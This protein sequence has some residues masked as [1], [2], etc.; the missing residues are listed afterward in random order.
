MEEIAFDVGVTRVIDS[1]LSDRLALLVGAGL[2]MAPP[3]SLPSAAAIAASAKEK[4]D[5]MFGATRP[6]LATA[7]EEQ[8]E[9][10][11]QRGELAGFYF[12]T[13]IDQNAFAGPP[14]IGHN[15][16]ADLLL[17]RAI[18]TAVT[19]NVDTLIET[20]GQFLFGQIGVGIDRNG[21]AALRPD[22]SPLLKI[23]GC[24]V[25]DCPN[26]VWAPGQ[27][28]AAPVAGRIADSAEWLN[29]RL[30]D[31]DLLIVG[32]WTDWDYLNN[33]LAATLGAVSPVRIIVVDPADSATFAEKAPE[34]YALGQRASLT[35]QHVRTS[36]ADFL[37][38]V[39]REFSRSFV[40]RVLHSGVSDYVT[41]FGSSP[42]AAWIEPPI[43]DNDT[44][45]RVR[46]DLEGCVPQEPAKER[47]PHAGNLV[48]LTLLQLQAR[49]ANSDGQF[50]VLNNR[51]VRVIRTVDK[52]LHRVVAEF[53]REMA[54]SVAPDVVIA[55]GAE[56]QALPTD[57]VRAES[58]ATIARGNKSRWMTR[59]EAVQELG[60]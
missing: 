48:G 45:W 21:V 1:I 19:T 59:T 14:N 28:A 53:E 13:L 50:W 9:F 46:R 55:V 60:L 42:N 39:R 26:M 18:Q 38:S 25:L 3:S 22:I 51:R 41:Q 16:V 47:N 37:D 17:V 49:G 36:G 34:L 56:A 15:A 8:A 6:P 27:L 4:Y 30:L 24:R 44:L 7:I 33:V 40:R 52:L 54:P 20:A 35:F 10:F 29:G 31:R 43:M 23:H 12:R 11:F 57:I 32:Y 5:A 2:S 58:R